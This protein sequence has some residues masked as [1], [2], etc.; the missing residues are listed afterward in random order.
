MSR[1]SKTPDESGNYNQSMRVYPALSGITLFE[2][3]KVASPIVGTAPCGCPFGNAQNPGQ[4]AT[5]GC[6]YNRLIARQ[7]FTRNNA[8]LPDAEYNLKVRNW[9]EFFYSDG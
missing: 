8:I 1:P 9:H 7:F 2:V 6:P 4:T 3:S 5:G